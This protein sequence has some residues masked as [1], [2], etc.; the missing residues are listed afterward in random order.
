MP[1][2][3]IEVHSSRLITNTE[4]NQMQDILIHSQCPNE[5]FVNSI[6]DYA[7]YDGTVIQIGD[8]D[9]YKAHIEI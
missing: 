6:A 9:E 1:V 8:G 4:L 5:S 2:K 3:V 7:S